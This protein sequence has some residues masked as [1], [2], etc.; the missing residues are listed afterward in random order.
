MLRLYLHNLK[1]VKSQL[2]QFSHLNFA[3]MNRD[4][5]TSSKTKS[6]YY[7]ESQLFYLGLSFGALE[8]SVVSNNIH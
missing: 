2:S 4:F 1:T 6:W 8:H 5:I 3:N 7:F